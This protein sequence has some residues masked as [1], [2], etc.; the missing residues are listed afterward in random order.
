MK[1]I[2]K[3][4]EIKENILEKFKKIPIVNIDEAIKFLKEKE[5]ADRVE[6]VN[7]KWEVG[8]KDGERPLQF[9]SDEDLIE[10]CK[11]QRDAYWS[12]ENEN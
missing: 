7:V 1:Q 10:W 2:N 6:E 4:E 11:E 5:G 3:V 8:F 12:D 9:Y